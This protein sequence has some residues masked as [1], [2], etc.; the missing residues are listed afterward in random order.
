MPETDPYAVIEPDPLDAMVEAL[1]MTLRVLRL[2]G[3]RPDLAALAT[4]KIIEIANA[5]ERQSER[6]AAA[7][8]TLGH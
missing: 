5:G 1:G 3:R 4:R 8:S 7:L 6:L 2:S